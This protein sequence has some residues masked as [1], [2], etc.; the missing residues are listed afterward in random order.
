[1][2]RNCVAAYTLFEYIL[3][4]KGIEKKVKY[5]LGNIFYL[6]TKFQGYD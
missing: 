4:V 5:H 6:N 3:E 2:E 1:M